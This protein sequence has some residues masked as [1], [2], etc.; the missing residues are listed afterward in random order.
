MTTLRNRTQARITQLSSAAP[1]HLAFLLPPLD[2]NTRTNGK[3]AEVA[4]ESRVKR[5][6]VRLRSAESREMLMS[7]WWR[8]WPILYLKKIIVLMIVFI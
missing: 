3:R 1:P 2:V 5:A 6:G 7:E 4:E 8:S